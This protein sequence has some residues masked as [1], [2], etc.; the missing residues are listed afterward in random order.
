[1]ARAGMARWRKKNVAAA[2]RQFA[3]AAALNPK[4]PNRLFD[5]G[6]AVAA[7]GDL[8]H[9]APLLARAARTGA[10]RAAYNLGTAALGKKQ[11]DQAVSWLRKALLAHPNDPDVKRN[12]ELALKLLEKQ[13]QDRKKQK[14]KGQDRKKPKDQKKDRR[15][16]RN[17]PGQ[18]TPTPTPT[19]AGGA[20]GARP[21]PRPANPLY[22][23]LERAEASARAKMNRPTPH[24]ARVEEDW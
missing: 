1:M 13:K 14:K 11:A 3:G 12:Y 21:T 19:P 2:A 18:A 7:A 24:P 20:K 17:T 22:G 10:P 6:T 9:A 15:Q 16:Q 4:N 23:A 5:L 8:K